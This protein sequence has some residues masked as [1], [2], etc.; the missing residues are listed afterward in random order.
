LDYRHT[1]KQTKIWGPPTGFQTKRKYLQIRHLDPEHN[2]SQSKEKVKDKGC[3]F[4]VKTK[5]T[6]E[7]LLMKHF[8]VSLENVS[9][10]KPKNSDASLSHVY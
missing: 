6:N 1:R 2:K 9:M 3:F 10:T 7:R 8:W 5:Q 4:V